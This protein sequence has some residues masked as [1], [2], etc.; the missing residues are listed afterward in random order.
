MKRQLRSLDKRDFIL[1]GK[2]SKVIWSISAPLMLSNLIQTVYNLTDSMFITLI[3][4]L[5]VGAVSFLFP[6]IYNNMDVAI[7]FSVAAMSLIAQYTGAGRHDNEKTCAVQLVILSFILCALLIIL[8]Y[9]FGPMLAGM[10]GLNGEMYEYGMD[11]FMIIIWEIPFIF[12]MNIYSA[13]RQGQGDTV[14]PMIYSVISVI[15]NIILDPIFM[16]V[17]DMGLQGA[18][19]ATILARVAVSIPEVITL[20]NTQTGIRLRLRYLQYN[21]ESMKQLLSVGFP[22]MIGETVSNMGFLV[23][24]FFIIG[25]GDI[26]M[27]AFAIGNR[28]LNVV[29]L[30]IMGIGS[31]LAVIIGQNLG[32]K[33]IAR[34]RE[35]VKT[36]MIIG[37]SI[38][39]LGGLLMVLTADMTVGFFA[40]NEGGIF[41]QGKIYLIYL[42]YSNVFMAIFMVFMGVFQGSGQSRSMMVMSMIRLWVIRL[43]ILWLL[44]HFTAMA[45]TSVWISMSF[46]NAVV[47]VL[48]WI[49]YRKGKWENGRIENDKN[50][51]L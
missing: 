11:Y 32:A 26:T 43:P 20:A 24:N 36:S 12:L 6:I 8:N 25:Y 37:C 47:D 7:C 9:A 15:L 14:S 1:T 27:T 38:M 51:V 4:P 40:G 46:S 18:A 44:G 2:L 33:R 29:T 31:G 28:I 39:I 21:R 17:F 35:A 3:N 41:D 45:E 10:L 22:A 5:A 30:P 42:G 34:A 13:V 23:L 16:F 48:C 50:C 19:V 49:V